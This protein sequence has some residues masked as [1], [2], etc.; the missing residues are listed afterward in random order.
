[1]KPSSGPVITV[2]ERRG[3]IALL[4]IILIS[5]AIV[6][7]R[8]CHHSDSAADDVAELCS[9]SGSAELSDSVSHDSLVSAL[10]DAA[11]R[12]AVGNSKK[13]TGNRKQRTKSRRDTTKSRNKSQRKTFPPR[14]PRDE[15]VD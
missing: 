13:K 1:M 2:G 10:T 14:N 5:L 11:D 7:V 6:S 15:R 12:E 9:Q 8:Q 3:L 4:V